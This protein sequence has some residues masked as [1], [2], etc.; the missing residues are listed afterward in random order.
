MKSF[1]FYPVQ[2]TRV[3]IRH[4][5]NNKERNRSAWIEMYLV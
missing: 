5:N 4:E 2:I 1:H 3:L